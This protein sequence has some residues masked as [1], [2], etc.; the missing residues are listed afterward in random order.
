[1]CE[2]VTHVAAN[3]CPHMPQRACLTCALKQ[4]NFTGDLPV[5]DNEADGCRSERGWRARTKGLMKRVEEACL[6]VHWDEEPGHKEMLN[7]LN[8]LRTYR[9]ESRR[10]CP[11]QI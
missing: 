6:Q 11:W 1:M 3:M 4:A 5:E 9:A 8:P 7:T 10:H 2:N